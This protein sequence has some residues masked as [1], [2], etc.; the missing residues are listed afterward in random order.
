MRKTHLMA[1]L[2]LESLLFLNS[3]EQTENEILEMRVSHHKQTGYGFIGPQITYL[4]QEEDEI[5]GEEWNIAFGIEDFDY[6]WG[7]TY[8]IL[9]AKKYYDEPLADAPS[10]RYIFLKEISKKKVETG[11]QF[12]LILQRRYDDGAVENFVKGD[13]ESGFSI[14]GIKSFDCAD[15]CDDLTKE[16]DDRTLLTGRFEFMEDGEIKLVDLK[17]QIFR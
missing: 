17:S 6:E 5:G 14:L 16:R 8:D 4:V 12:E 11:T 10:F 2:L 3:C 15:L 7:F 1:F 9:V 13:K